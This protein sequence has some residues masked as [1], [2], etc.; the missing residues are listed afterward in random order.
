MARKPGIIVYLVCALFFLEVSVQAHNDTSCEDPCIRVGLMDRLWRVTDAFSRNLAAAFLK[1]QQLSYALHQYATRRAQIMMM[2][3]DFDMLFYHEGAP[4]PR[5]IISKNHVFEV[6]ATA[7]GRKGDVRLAGLPQ[8]AHEFT[9]ALVKGDDVLQLLP[10]PKGLYRIEHVE[11]AFS[12]LD[13]GRVDL[14]AEFATKTPSGYVVP[15]FNPE[16]H[17]AVPLTGPVPIYITFRNTE[18]GQKL[19]DTFDRWF[20]AKHQRGELIRLYDSELLYYAYPQSFVA[21]EQKKA[22]Q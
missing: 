15:G 5:M 3:G 2:R 21:P 12:M 17:A 1:D 7:V 19:R 9:V 6:Y 18:K 11:Q 16:K 10:N 22:Q 13:R 4:Y 8:N 14:L 20:F